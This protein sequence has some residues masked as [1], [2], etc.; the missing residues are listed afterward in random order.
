MS[1]SRA[2]VPAPPRAWPGK[3][4]SC[5]RRRDVFRAQRKGGGD[6]R[7][8]HRWYH[9]SIC[10]ECVIGLQPYLPEPGQGQRTVSQWSVADLRA[11][12]AVLRMPDDDV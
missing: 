7:R 8:G 4:R 9:S 5:N 12:V 1:D 3:C 10:A 11:I 2:W 6:Y